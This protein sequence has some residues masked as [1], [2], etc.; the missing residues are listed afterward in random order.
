MKIIKFLQ[1][2]FQIVNFFIASVIVGILFGWWYLPQ[3]SESSSEVQDQEKSTSSVNN[4][5]ENP[6]L[7]DENK[8]PEIS[9]LPT[10]TE[11][12]APSVES[13]VSSVTE[14]LNS[15]LNSPQTIENQLPQIPQQQVNPSPSTT[16]QPKQI[17][18]TETILAQ[19]VYGHFPF[20]EATKERL[21]NMGKYYHRT[22]FLDR[23]AGEAFKRM[24]AD[25]QAQG[26][27]LVLISG[28]RSIS[29][30]AKLF[31]K[32]IQK[33]GSK[34]AASKL[35][36]P[37]GHSEHHTGYALDIGDGKQPSL[38]LKFQFENTEAYRW[39]VNNAYKYG[40]ELSFPKNNI[41][42]VSFEPW[43]WRYVGS[44]RANSIFALP[45]TL[46]YQN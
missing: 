13:N 20:S 27:D 23:E 30:Q 2:N 24:K 9:S 32:Q 37:P 25:A 14:S 7:T 5:S 16:N 33:R 36:A 22:E 21:I 39:L 43:H 6:P 19:T 8:P 44:N 35:S 31:E 38:D 3:S 46:L 10:P 29:D 15:A 4:P 28:F 41:Q 1:S 18:P 45:R 42:G 34:E 12:V 11:S 40:F 17:S 26:V